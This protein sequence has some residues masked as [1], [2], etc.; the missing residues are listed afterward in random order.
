MQK[1]TILLAFLFSFFTLTAQTISYHEQTIK[2]DGILD[3]K[4]WSELPPV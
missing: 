3:E 2:A 1:I 4:V